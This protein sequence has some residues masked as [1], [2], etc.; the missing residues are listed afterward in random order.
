M[1]ID[2]F[3]WLRFPLT[4]PRKVEPIERVQKEFPLEKQ[5]QQEEEKEEQDNCKP[6]SEPRRPG[7]ILSIWV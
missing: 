7:S 3:R 2:Y 1:F 6:E 4:G 5:E